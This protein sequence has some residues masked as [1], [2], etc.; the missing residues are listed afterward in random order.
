QEIASYRHDQH[1]PE[2][3]GERIR[4]L[5]E[6]KEA[7]REC[8]GSRDLGAQLFTALVRGIGVESRM[9]A[10]LQPSGFG[11]TKAEQAR[12]RKPVSAAKEESS[13]DNS[14]DE[15][16]EAPKAQARAQRTPAKQT[17]RSI[18]PQG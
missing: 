18:G 6:F 15:S 2:I 10:S 12:L 9:V 17:K 14:E 5:G 16:K 3:H 13:Q 8:K 1:D 4:N 11:F 7:A